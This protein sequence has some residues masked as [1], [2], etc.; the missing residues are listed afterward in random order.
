MQL[1][2]S[3]CP[4]GQ[5]SWSSLHAPLAPVPEVVLEA[6]LEGGPVVTA[7]VL[8]GE[9]PPALPDDAPPVLP[10]APER[11]TATLPQLA[12][13]KPTMTEEPIV[14]AS[15]SFIPAKIPLLGSRRCRL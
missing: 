13:A 12:M 5:Q 10:A 4:P 3:I 2:A 1:V 14:A 6:V 9:P 11:T 15:R 7:V 8:A